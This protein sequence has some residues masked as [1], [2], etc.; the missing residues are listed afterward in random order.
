MSQAGGSGAPLVG[1]DC[2]AARI[3]SITLCSPLFLGTRAPAPLADL[4]SS[5]GS[6]FILDPAPGEP[7]GASAPGVTLSPLEFL[8]TL[9]LGDLGDLGKALGETFGDAGVS[10]LGNVLS[11]LDLTTGGNLSVSIAGSGAGSGSIV[12]DLFAAVSQ[13]CREAV[14]SKEH[15]FSE[16]SEV[17]K[18]EEDVMCWLKS[19]DP[20]MSTSRDAPRGFSAVRTTFGLTGGAS[21]SHRGPESSSAASTAKVGAEALTT[22]ISALIAAN[23]AK[24]VSA[25]GSACGLLELKASAAAASTASGARGS[26]RRRT[27]VRSGVATRPLSIFVRSQLLPTC[28]FSV[29]Q[30]AAHSH[31]PIA[32]RDKNK[33]R[34]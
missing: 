6:L 8:C 22:G 13:L 24:V 31:V 9:E 3:A 17:A 21:V 15:M 19:N 25:Q 16:P 5:P 10:S 29:E 27:G 4:V 11:T 34:P 20:D 12:G 33:V 18:S 30:A 28:Q 7:L 2:R 23:G 14:T 26:E 1:D 32:D